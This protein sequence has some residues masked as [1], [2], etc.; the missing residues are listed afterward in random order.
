MSTTTL[1]CDTSVL[2]YLGRI[3]QLQL[4]PAPYQTIVTPEQVAVE[5]DVGRIMRADTVD[6][7]QLGFIAVVPVAQTV[8]DRLPSNRLGKGERAVIALAREVGGAVAGLD[9]RLARQY[10][11]SLGLQVTGSVGILLKA[12]GAGL[13]PVVQ[14]MLEAIQN[15]GFYLSAPLLA[16]ALQLAGE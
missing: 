15:A 9:E 10:A 13:L 5:L 16:A 6:P 4:W 7:R 8:V 3:Q 2:L 12:K 11:L 14:P 1:V